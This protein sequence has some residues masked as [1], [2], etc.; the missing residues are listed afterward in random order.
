MD[1]ECQPTELL[2]DI[3]RV[4]DDEPPKQPAPKKAKTDKSIIVK[5]WCPVEGAEDEKHEK[6]EEERAQ[7]S[8]GK[9]LVVKF[10]SLGYYEQLNDS[11]FDCILQ[12]LGAALKKKYDDKTLFVDDAPEVMTDRLPADT[13]FDLEIMDGEEDGKED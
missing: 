13:E 1:K 3:K 9:E 12:K 5:I 11:Q 4:A 6:D 8:P 7:E 2:V 10:Q